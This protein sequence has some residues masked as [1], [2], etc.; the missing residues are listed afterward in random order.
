MCQF[1]PGSFR[2]STG[3]GQSEP[4]ADEPDDLAQRRLRAIGAKLDHVMSNGE[5]RA[6]VGWIDPDLASV[7]V[8]LAIG[9]ITSERTTGYVPLSFPRRGRSQVDNL[10]MLK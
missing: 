1:N 6:R 7:Q 4:I 5:P 2:P 3:G 8:V 10:S 9:R